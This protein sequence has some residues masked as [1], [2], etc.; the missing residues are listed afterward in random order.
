VWPCCASCLSRPRAWTIQYCVQY[1]DQYLLRPHG[2]HLVKKIVHGS[3]APCR[4]CCPAPCIK[5]FNFTRH[6]PAFYVLRL[7]AAAF[8][9]LSGEHGAWT[10]RPA[11]HLVQHT[12]CL[13][14]LAVYRYRYALAYV[15]CSSH[16]VPCSAYFVPVY[17]YLLRPSV[18]C[19][20][21]TARGPRALQCI[22]FSPMCSMSLQF[23]A[24][25]VLVPYLLVHLDCSS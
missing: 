19:L 23:Y 1:S 15:P 8:S 2:K 5:V 10:A 6:V 17:R 14:I 13:T 7:P 3:R 4:A 24:G 20:V 12:M 9:G 18:G 21:S 22:L 11:V 16:Y 25:C